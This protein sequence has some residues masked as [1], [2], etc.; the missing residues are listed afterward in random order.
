M[1][2]SIYLFLA[3]LIMIGCEEQTDSSEINTENWLKRKI[4]ISQKDSLE[5]GKSYLSVYSQIYSFSQHEKYNLTGMISLR[6]T[7]DVDTIYLLKTE[8]FDTQGALLRTYFDTP[9]YLA[10]ME[11]T[12]IIIDQMDVAGGTGSNFMF[13]WKIPLDCPEPLFEGVMISMQG[14]QGLSFTTQ[15]K[16]I[17]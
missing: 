2:K 14:T 10:P 12:E 6:N 16:R 3:L 13:E 4:D 5:Y 17:R 9:I 11:T 1:R 15:A 8:Y 7:S